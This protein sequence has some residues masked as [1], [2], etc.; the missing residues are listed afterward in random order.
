MYLIKSFV[1]TLFETPVTTPEDVVQTP[2]SVPKII[3]PPV[4]PLSCAPGGANNPQSTGISGRFPSIFVK[5]VPPL[6]L[7]QTLGT[8]KLEMVTSTL[9]VEGSTSIE[10]IY[11]P[12]PA[13]IVVLNETA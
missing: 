13:G 8:P 9:F 7:S 10:D 3:P 1:I 6:V 4:V 12:L 11:E 5:V 2:R